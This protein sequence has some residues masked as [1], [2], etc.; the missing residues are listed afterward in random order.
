MLDLLT[1]EQVVLLHLFKTKETVDHA[2][3]SLLLKLWDQD[4]LCLQEAML[5]TTL[6]KKSSTVLLPAMDAEEDGLQLLCN[7]YKITT[8]LILMTTHTPLFREIANY[9]KLKEQLH[10]ELLTHQAQLM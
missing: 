2:G 7:G 4:M 1:G 5:L 10:Q 6:N 9:L 3:L 8:L